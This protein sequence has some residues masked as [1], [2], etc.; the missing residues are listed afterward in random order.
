[1]RDMHP[2]T[3]FMWLWRSNLGLHTSKASTLPSQPHTQPQMVLFICH[4]PAFKTQPKLSLWRTVVPEARQ[5]AQWWCTCHRSI[6][7][8][9][10]PSTHIKPNSDAYSTLPINPAAR[11]RGSATS[12]C[13]ERACH[14]I[15]DGKQLRKTP[16]STSGI[17]HIQI[18]YTHATT[19]AH[20]HTEN[21]GG[22]E[23]WRGWTWSSQGKSK[24]C[25][26]TRGVEDS[27]N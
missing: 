10:I 2:N 9:Q 18:W 13:I 7:T 15:K 4:A 11:D 21:V 6:R 23:S 8:V 5:M 1:M 27:G 16:G 26:K 22:W 19:C 3:W 24:K 17:C 20:T 12:G 25:A 14:N